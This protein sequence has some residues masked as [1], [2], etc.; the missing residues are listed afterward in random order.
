MTAV[1]HEGPC[2]SIDAVELYDE[3][4]SMHVKQSYN[5]DVVST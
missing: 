4:I 3:T 5:N 1:H 2:A